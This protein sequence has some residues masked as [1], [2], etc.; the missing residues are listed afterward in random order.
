MSD[1]EATR[2]T[3][4][5]FTPDQTGTYMDAMTGGDQDPFDITRLSEGTLVWRPKTRYVALMDGDQMAARAGILTVSASV[6]E[7]H[8]EVVGFGGVLVAFDRRGRGLARA[9]MAETTQ[10]AR[11]LGP[12]L[13]LLWCFEDRAGLYAALGWHRIP[14]PV[15][16]EQPSGPHVMTQVAMWTPLHPDAQIPHGPVEI[17]S[18]PF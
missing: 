9:V 10:V 8:F 5:E 13:G 4:A 3:T 15:T 14:H 11:T 2:F 7:S 18:L 1:I 17:H 12:T 6:G 16:V